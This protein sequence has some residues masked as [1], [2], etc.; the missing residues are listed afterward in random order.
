[1][2]Q[3]RAVERKAGMPEKW[4]V[5]VVGAGASGLMCAAVAGARGR[6]VLVVDHAAKPCQKL[7]ITGG[8][9]C[10]F[11]NRA[12]DC[13]NFV[14][15]VP[16]FCKSALSRF[17]PSDFIKMLDDHGI[18]WCER[19]HGQLFLKGSAREIA[20]LL[21]D[22]CRQAG[23][24][25]RSAC[26]VDQVTLASALP[27]QEQTTAGFELATSSGVLACDSLVVASGGLSVPETGASAFGFDLAA[28]FGI[29]VVAP[30]PGLVPLTLAP[31]DREKFGPLSGIAVEVQISF[32]KHA[33]RENLL[34]T[35][36]GLSGPVVLQISNYWRP[37]GRLEINFCPDTDL[38]AG[39]ID[40]RQNRPLV[41]VKTVLSDLLPKR[42]AEALL[43]PTIAEMQ[44]GQLSNRLLEQ[45]TQLVQRHPLVPA[46]TEGYRVAEVTRGGIDC[47]EVSSK[48]FECSKIKGLYFIG[49]VLDVTGWLGGYNLQW[50]WSSGHCAGQFV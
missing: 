6:R 26:R 48:T 23:V 38:A 45:L 40:A 15:R 12:V 37:G 30:V 47:G 2:I 25:I 21:L 24:T 11:T 50:A 7:L 27:A 33:F 42:L 13:N 31:E 9:R 1:M 5:V 34:F 29:N 4:D 36:R 17:K 44:C 19:E 49:E 35:H 39:F 22:K 28:Q 32:E 3:A 14:S 16:R 20:D 41:R 18:A 10:N 8:G 43:P 46:G